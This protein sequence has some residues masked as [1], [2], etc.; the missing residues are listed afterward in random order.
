[1]LCSHFAEAQLP[2]N[3]DNPPTVR[4]PED[5]PSAAMLFCQLVHP[6]ILAPDFAREIN[7]LALPGLLEFCDKYDSLG[8]IHAWLRPEVEQLVKEKTRLLG[9][10]MGSKMGFAGLTLLSYLL[11][12]PELFRVATASLIYYHSPEDFCSDLTVCGAGIKDSLQMKERLLGTEPELVQDDLADFHHQ[13][14]SIRPRRLMFRDC[15]TSGRMRLQRLATGPTTLQCQMLS[16]SRPITSSP[17]TGS[18]P[19]SSCV[20]DKRSSWV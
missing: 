5:S 15:A 12:D 18:S 13:T 1:M 16:P 17:P 2:F 4:L 11:H 19:L 3:T 10:E 20:K 6:T 8:S 7:Y 14:R 9:K